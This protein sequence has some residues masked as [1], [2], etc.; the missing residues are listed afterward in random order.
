MCALRKER[1]AKNE[2]DDRARGLLPVLREA[3]DN[4]AL[5]VK[6]SIGKDASRGKLSVGGWS[7]AAGIAS[8]SLSYLPSRDPRSE[9][10]DAVV[11]ISLAGE[12]PRFR[13]DIAW[14]DGRIVTEV[15]NQEILGATEKEVLQEVKK[16]AQE[17]ATHM[18][19]SL[20]SFIANI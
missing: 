4:L 11:S 6:S 15:A 1:S 18:A 12:T 17:A 19:E 7:N 14:S 3:V 13:A 9:S 10:L 2:I 20:P 5:Q 16:A 8:A